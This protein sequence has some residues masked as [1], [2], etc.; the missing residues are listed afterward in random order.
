LEAVAAD[1]LKSIGL[2]QQGYPG[3]GC[4]N[5]SPMSQQV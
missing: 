5:H 3:L 2:S 4:S 1:F